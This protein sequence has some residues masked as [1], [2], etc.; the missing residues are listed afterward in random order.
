MKTHSRNKAIEVLFSLCFFLFFRISSWLCSIP[1]WLTLILHFVC[2]LSWWWFIGTLIA[3]LVAGVIRWA[4][5]D[6][7]RWG[8]RESEKAAPRE[9][10]NPYSKKNEDLFQ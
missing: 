7:A 8:A 3:W 6:F 4:L 9:N 2:G 10:K 5:I 1:A